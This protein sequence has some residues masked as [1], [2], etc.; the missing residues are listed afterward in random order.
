MFQK[1]AKRQAQI[2]AAIVLTSP[3]FGIFYL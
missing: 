2:G 3:Y 1:R